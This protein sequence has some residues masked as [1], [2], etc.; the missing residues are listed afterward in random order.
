M[1]NQ[2]PLL[3]GASGVPILYGFR[4]VGEERE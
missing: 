1:R 2:E 3:T 4:R